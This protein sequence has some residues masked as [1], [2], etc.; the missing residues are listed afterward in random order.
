VSAD[1]ESAVGRRI[2]YPFEEDE[3]KVMKAGVVVSYDEEVDKHTVQFDEDPEGEV[4]ALG[5]FDEED[6]EWL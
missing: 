5:I 4:Y 2:R 6:T 3:E 1:P